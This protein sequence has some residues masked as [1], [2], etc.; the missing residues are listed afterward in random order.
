MAKRLWLG[1]FLCT[2]AI[3]LCGVYR[4]PTTVFA[5]GTA[6][7]PQWAQNL[8]HTAVFEDNLHL[9]EIG[10]IGGRV[11]VDDHRRSPSKAIPPPTLAVG[12]RGN[13]RVS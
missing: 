2:L 11:A 13:C 12:G 5:Q 9:F 1:V 3:A 7:R 8:Q 6:P 4:V 10:H